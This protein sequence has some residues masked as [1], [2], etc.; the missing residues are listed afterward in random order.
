[1]SVSTVAR[2]SQMISLV[3]EIANNHGLTIKAK[4]LTRPSGWEGKPRTFA[5]LVDFYQ[6]DEHADTPWLVH[7][8]VL[9][10]YQPSQLTMHEWAPGK[11]AM[12]LGRQRI[13]L[14]NL[15]LEYVS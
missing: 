2:Q 7:T 1:M 13:N 6:Q 5:Y 3:Q 4:P 12:A 8:R 15:E 11:F 9:P 10:Y 14:L